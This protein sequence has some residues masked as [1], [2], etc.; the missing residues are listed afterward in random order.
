M[1]FKDE[2][3]GE[4]LVDILR[5][6]HE[7]VPDANENGEEIFDPV[8]VVGDQKTMRRGLEGQFSVS[9]AYPKQR[10]LKGLFF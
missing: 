5:N 9:N 8:P 10:R 2:N 1:L 4:D 7:W 6:L 3:L